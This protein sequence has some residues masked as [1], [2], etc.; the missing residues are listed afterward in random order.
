M[1]NV[2]AI[3]IGL[4]AAIWLAP[5]GLA[6]ADEPPLAPLPHGVGRY[7]GASTAGALA[8]PSPRLA[9]VTRQAADPNSSTAHRAPVVSPQQYVP[10]A[11]RSSP[12]DHAVK[13]WPQDI[14]PWARFT[15]GPK[16]EGYHVG[17]GKVPTL[18]GSGR[19]VLQDEGTF[20]VDF[21]PWYMRVALWRGGPKWFQGGTGQY[22]PD[23]KNWPFH[24]SFRRADANHP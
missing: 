18:F 13:G 5:T 6:G 14:A 15:Y 1:R 8:T 9:P 4:Q 7:Q 17:G 3:L 19:P 12:H 16:Y 11:D 22:D 21:N 23:R 24:L 10:P 2:A 20:G